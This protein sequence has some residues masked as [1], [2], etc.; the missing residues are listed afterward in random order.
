METRTLIDRAFHESAGV[1]LDALEQFAALDAD[2]RKAVLA[3]FLKSP[4]RDVREGVLDVLD[5]EALA[6]DGWLDALGELIDSSPEA[7]PH[8]C[9]GVLAL[10]ARYPAGLP[11]KYRRF[12]MNCV[13]R[14]DEDVC[15]QALCFLEQQECGGE[16]YLGVLEKMLDSRDSEIRIVA[17]QGVTRLRPAWALEKLEK[18]AHRAGAYE[19]FH[20]LE[21]RMEIGDSELR[22]KL[23]PDVEHC[24]HDGRF[25]YPAIVLLKKYGTAAAVDELLGVAGRFFEDDTLRIAAADAA[26]SLGSE[27]GFAMLKK[28]AKRSQNR[29]YAMNALQEL[30]NSDG[31]G[32]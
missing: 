5:D 8:I 13:E 14:G 12:G 28:F 4:Y 2:G 16:E 7:E 23:E 19:S 9:I 29:E 31:S 24:L 26:A 20:I 27:K 17:I 30:E 1:R 6:A 11:E 32:V 10:L 15:Y 18:M 3:G 25:C 21:A 22:R